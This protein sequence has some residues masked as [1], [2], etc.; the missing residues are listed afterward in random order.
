MS[1]TVPLPHIRT[2]PRAASILLA[3]VLTA[4]S[5]GSERS[6]TPSPTASSTAPTTSTTTI[7]TTTTAPPPATTQTPTT[8][9]ATP[10]AVISRGDPNRRMVALTFDA[11]SDV[12]FTAQILAVLDRSGVA[13]TFGITG[14]WAE[15]NPDLVRRIASAGHL[16]MNHTYEHRSFTGVSA[17][18]AIADAG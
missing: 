16:L 5:G 15:S 14:R 2:L 12:G 17:R 3:L 18:P 7:S 6:A 1:Q 9:S 10:A 13:A 8:T 4:C 11:G